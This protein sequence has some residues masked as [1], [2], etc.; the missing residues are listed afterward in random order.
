M[1]MKKSEQLE[2]FS[3]CG[4]LVIQA[5][6]FREATYIDH[7]RLFPKCV[8]GVEVVNASRNEFE[9]NMAKL[10]AAHYGLLEFAGSDNHCAG[11]Q[12]SF[13]GLCFET[14]LLCEQD[15]VNRV[16]SGQINIFTL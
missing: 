4:A 8:H 15:F 13:A 6:P 16:K 9:N 2:Y 3:Q 10:Y 14:P 11:R 12:Q 1:D 7:I 5:H